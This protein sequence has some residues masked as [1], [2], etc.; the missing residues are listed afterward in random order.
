MS[1]MRS[2]L[3]TVKN[4][5]TKGVYKPNRTGIDTISDFGQYST[6][7][8]NLEKG[9]P[10]LTTK[11]LGEK[12]WQSLAAELIWF[13]S[14]ETSIR[15]LQKYTKIW[16]AWA[17]EEGNVRTAYGRFWRRF[18]MPEK[19]IEGEGWLNEHSPF[20]HREA[21]GSFSVDQI[22]YVIDQLKN[23]PNSR[24]MVVSAWHPGNAIASVLPPCHLMFICN[25]N[26]GKLNLHLTQRSA[27]LA[28]G[29]PF[30][31][32]SYALLAQMLGREAGLTPNVFGHTMIDAHVYAGQNGARGQFY[33][34][35]L[36]E[37]QEQLRKARTT[38]DMRRVRDWHTREIEG[39][40]DEGYDH[41]PGL[42]E[43]LTRHPRTLPTVIIPDKRI[44]DLVLN[45]ETVSSFVLKGYNPHPAI[46]FKVAV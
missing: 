43:Q 39:I 21:D 44:D 19:G 10:L 6:T 42:L 3:T 34:E 1:T 30:N 13:L 29:V 17:D 37:L 20:L 5:L 4:V 36:P 41:V 16:D 8:I 26:E 46:R 18:P 22:A 15:E 45:D 23:N 31:I 27:D 9:F 24:R 38:S 35:R 32:A 11:D 2:Y 40:P 25:V 12:R 7:S 14:G 28:L 33:K